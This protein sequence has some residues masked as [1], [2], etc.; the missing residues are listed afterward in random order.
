MTIQQSYIKIMH[1][2]TA[3][4]PDQVGDSSGPV[5]DEDINID[6]QV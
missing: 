4:V 1:E 3:M 6:F 2:L 5:D